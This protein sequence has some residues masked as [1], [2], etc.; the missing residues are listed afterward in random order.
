LP[1]IVLS[2]AQGFGSLQ[3]AS[4]DRDDR[5]AARR[6]WR[7]LADGNKQLA[8][9]GECRVNRQS[10]FARNPMELLPITHHQ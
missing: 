8:A 6:V 2:P 3:R 10:L 4:L 1:R 5:R 9:A 7:N